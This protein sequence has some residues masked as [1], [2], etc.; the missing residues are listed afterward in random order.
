MLDRAW[1]VA[2]KENNLVP[3][4]TIFTEYLMYIDVKLGCSRNVKRK[5]SWGSSSQP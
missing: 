3:I 5:V 1:W 2:W 4:K